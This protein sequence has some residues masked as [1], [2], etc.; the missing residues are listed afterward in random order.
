[1]LKLA[2]APSSAAVM[3]AVPGATPVAS[4]LLLIVATDGLDEL[5]LASVVISLF[6][7]SE[8]QPKAVNCWVD[9]TNMPGVTTREDKVAVV[10]VRVVLAVILPELA[11][12]VTVPALMAVARP[13]LAV[14]VATEGS[15]E[16]QVNVVDRYVFTLWLVPSENVPMAKNCWA[17][18]TAML[19]LIGVSAAEERL[20]EVTARV[21]LPD[22]P[23]VVAIIIAVPAAEPAVATPLLLSIVAAPIEIQEI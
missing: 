23:A 2:E 1:M 11:V 20:A 9:P 16:L 10:T 13:L 21:V 14:T 22:I 7:P 3:V 18:P 17:T 8:Y 19:G 6:P 12:M 15:E 4:P 5:Q